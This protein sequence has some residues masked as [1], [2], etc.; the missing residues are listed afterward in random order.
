M[1]IVAILGDPENMSSGRYARW[2]LDSGKGRKGRRYMMA[3]LR[4]P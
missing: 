1:N 2:I 4:L 3:G